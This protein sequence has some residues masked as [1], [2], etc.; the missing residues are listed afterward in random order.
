L[1]EFKAAVFWIFCRLFVKMGKEGR[2]DRPSYCQKGA[3][4]VCWPGAADHG[5]PAAGWVVPLGDEP[6]LILRPALEG[7]L[8]AAGGSAGTDQLAV[9]G[10]NLACAGATGVA[11]CGAVGHAKDGGGTV[12]EVAESG[13][14]GGNPLAGP[15]GIGA[16]GPAPPDGWE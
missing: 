9:G 11:V 7:K 12:D 6:A 1:P 10:A 4:D 14:P 15:P 5:R 3:A 13:V 8:A 2:E 16:T